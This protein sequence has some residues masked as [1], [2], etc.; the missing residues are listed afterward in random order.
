ME[1]SGVC[2][3]YATQIDAEYLS[4][5]ASNDR[6]YIASSDGA[7]KA[8]AITDG[9]IDSNTQDLELQIQVIINSDILCGTTGNATFFDEVVQNY[10]VRVFGE[11]VTG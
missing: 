9:R 8:S 4:T 10:L 6:F 5:A 11:R 3:S 1:L 2:I 7:F